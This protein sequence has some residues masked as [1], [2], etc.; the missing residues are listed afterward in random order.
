MT[1]VDV[2]L[3]A[4]EEP[5]DQQP[6]GMPIQKIADRKS[7]VRLIRDAIQASGATFSA[8]SVREYLEKHNPGVSHRV[9]SSRLS[10]VLGNLVR[11]NELIALQPLGTPR[12]PKIYTLENPV[13]G[14]PHG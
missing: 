5:G 10:E 6:K 7:R 9:S 4:C 13:Q 1:D 14:S 8:K 12:K 11:E 2:T 3:F